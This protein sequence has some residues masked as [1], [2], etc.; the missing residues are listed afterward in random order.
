MPLEIVCLSDTHNQIIHDV[1]FGD[2]VI[3]S[4]DATNFGTI[5]EIFQFNEWFSA[6][7]HPYKIFVAGNHD[8]LFEKE[9]HLA[10]SLLSD[11]I[12][13]L[14][15]SGVTI[16]GIK[17]YGSPVTPA[18]CNW[19]FNV[20]ADSERMQAIWGNIPEDVG[21]LI[22]HGP[23]KNILDKVRNLNVGCNVLLE[24][25]QHLRCM[26]YHVFGHIHSSAGVLQCDRYTAINAAIC[27]NFRIP[28][29]KIQTFRIE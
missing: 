21:V 15:N 27:N 4:G 8:L 22:T 1:P 10:K 20:A 17:F 24:R 3:H 7:P 14:E 16:A 25:I 11:R 2:V 5:E 18:F 26:Q 9:K 29:R 13:Y 19:A 28:I 6:L 23:A 12:I